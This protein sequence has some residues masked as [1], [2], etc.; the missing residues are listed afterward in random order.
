MIYWKYQN[1]TNKK[2]FNNYSNKKEEYFDWNI[3]IINI[4]IRKRVDIMVRDRAH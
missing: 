4:I 2:H 3:L 1:T